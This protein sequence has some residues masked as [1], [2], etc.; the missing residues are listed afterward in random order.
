MFK[1]GREWFWLNEPQHTLEDGIL[2]LTCETKTD[3]WQRTHY[4]FRLDNG[5]ALLTKVKEDFSLTVCCSFSG[6]FPYD[7]AGVMVRIDAENWIKS[8][9]EWETEEYSRLGSVV[10]NLGYSDWATRDVPSSLK[11]IWYRVQSKGPDIFIHTSG[12]GVNWEQLR[13]THL[14]VYEGEVAIG[15]YA[16][17]PHTGG[18]E[19]TFSNLVV[20][21]S[22]WS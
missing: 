8:S 5:H 12:D 15:L 14:H 16:C 22:E 9:I 19:V 11:T 10:T 3:F 17:S 4:G 7:Q 2:K 20:G 21:P 13:V 1:D 6:Q 18:C